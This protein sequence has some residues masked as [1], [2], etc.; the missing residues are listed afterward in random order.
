LTGSP[1]L[2]RCGGALLLLA[3]LEDVAITIASS[4]CRHDVPT[5][6]H[7]LRLERTVSQGSGAAR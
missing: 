2:F 7:A 3:A 5:L 6:W 1:W 4:S